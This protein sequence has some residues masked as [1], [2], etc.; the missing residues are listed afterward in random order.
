MADSESDLPAGRRRGIYLLPNLLTT[1]TLFAGFYGIVASIDGNYRAAAIAIFVAAV[2]DGLD[3]R[4]AR[5]THTESDFGKQY[6]SL[7]DMV[8]FGMAPAIIA[9]QW[10][11]R[12]LAEFGWLWGKL[13]WLAA[14]L[15]AV[16]A[17]LRL[18]RFNVTPP[19]RDRR[20]FE[21]LP[22]P[23]ASAL[24]VNMVWLA[25]QQQWTGAATLALACIV[26]IAAAL[27][28]V[29][30]LP[31][32]SFKEISARGRISFTYVILIP[33]LFVLIAIDPPTVMFT[34]AGTYALSALVMAA[35]RRQRRHFVRRQRE[36]HTR[37][38]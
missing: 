16:G 3:G 19:S 11:L 25:S 22:S 1:G 8:A 23:A 24:V 31:Y 32:Y 20:F 6:D 29:S 12:G 2:L 37:Q 26:T 27:L 34:V 4:L 28:M 10:G 36:Q 17:A 7:A 21:G 30:R 5:L 9:Y 15:Y 18:A 13:G 35:W 14:F 33:L 38:S